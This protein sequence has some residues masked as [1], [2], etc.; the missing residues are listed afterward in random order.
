MHS[1]STLELPS[2]M[3]M[4]NHVGPVL[5]RV[6]DVEVID[7]ESCRF[8]HIFPLPTD[9][10]VKKFYEEEFY[11]SEKPGYF[12]SYERDKEWWLDI[13]YG[14]RLKMMESLLPSNDKRRVIDV[15]SG[16]GLFLEAAILRGWEQPLGIEPS[17][18]AVE[19]SSR[20]WPKVF[21]GSLAQF[22]AERPPLGMASAIHLSEV[23]EHVKRPMEM[24]EHCYS[25]LAPGGLLCVTVPNDFSLFQK[26]YLR[27]NPSNAPWFV[28]PRHHLNYF[29]FPSLRSVLIRTGFHCVEKFFSSFPIDLNLSMFSGDYVKH[30]ETGPAVHQDR[31]EFE[32]ALTHEERMHIYK[33]FAEAGIGREITI[34]ARKS[35]RSPFMS[36]PVPPGGE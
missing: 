15:G 8:K 25:L 13:V 33:Y 7:C 27:K 35:P 1:R 17:K 19:W 34:I 21:H 4:T 9:E 31:I 2:G 10:E 3:K 22:I 26:A 18:A 36:L 28:S 5:V 29:D 20:Y 14:D 6:G 23:L 30:P 32:T 11:Q 24:L 12:D 16:P